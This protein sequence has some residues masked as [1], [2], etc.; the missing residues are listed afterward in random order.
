MRWDLFHVIFNK[1]PVK[2]HELFNFPKKIPNR[3]KIDPGDNLHFSDY[4]DEQLT[5]CVSGLKDRDLGPSLFNLFSPP[6]YRYLYS[7]VLSFEFFYHHPP[8]DIIFHFL[9]CFEFTLSLIS[10]IEI[11]TKE[12][13]ITQNLEFITLALAIMLMLSSRQF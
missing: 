9:C 8:T 10:F 4:C 6:M 5:F 3:H 11:V 12:V 7:D 1:S 13:L 2:E